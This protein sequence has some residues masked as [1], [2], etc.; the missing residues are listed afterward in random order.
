MN[1]LISQ[2][3][4]SNLPPSQQ[5]E[6][7]TVK[8]KN[9]IGLLEKARKVLINQSKLDNIPSIDDPE[10]FSH[11]LDGSANGINTKIRS[12]KS[13]VMLISQN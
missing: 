1:Q 12:N 4:T 8:R 5:L 2:R 13:Q 3:S 10:Y 9:R 7:E 11:G 6:E